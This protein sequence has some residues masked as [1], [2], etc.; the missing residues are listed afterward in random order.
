MAR[1]VVN[2]P[3]Y[4]LIAG[5]GDEGASA[6]MV[7]LGVDGGGVPGRCRWDLANPAKAGALGADRMRRV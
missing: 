3:N 6:M 2:S 5:E 7:E 1:V 4:G